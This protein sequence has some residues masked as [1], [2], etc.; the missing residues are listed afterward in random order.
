ML[1]WKEELTMQI[2]VKSKQ[3]E[4][5]PRLRQI[6]DRKVQRLSRLVDD[7]TRIEVTV[8]EEQTRSAQDRYSVHLALTVGSHPIRSEVS[9]VNANM[10]LGLVL[11]K[12]IKQLSRQKD[13]QTTTL[14]HHTPPVKVL[15]LSRAGQLSALEEEEQESEFAS[16]GAKS[17]KRPKMARAQSTLSLG[18]ERNEEIW[19]RVLEIRRLPTKPMNHQE[20]IAQMQTLNLSFF[21]F[22]NEATDT[23]NVMYR[24]EK[25]GY[26]LL[27]PELE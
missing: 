9:A 21:P 27:L 7:D 10:A 23:V 14:R 8:T 11:D 19:S 15:S 16:M 2:V 18:E 26:G 3:F 13:K 17:E 20:V 22:Y 5:T 25:G 12:V 4:I 6:I 24:L 1:N